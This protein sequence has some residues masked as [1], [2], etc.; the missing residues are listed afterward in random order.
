MLHPCTFRKVLSPPRRPLGLSG[1][2]WVRSVQ[3]QK[4]PRPVCSPPFPSSA[5]PLVS[6]ALPSWWLACV[7]LDM[8]R[9]R[10]CGSEEPSLQLAVQV[11]TTDYDP[12]RLWV[13]AV[14]RVITLPYM[15]GRAV[16][17]SRMGPRNSDGCLSLRVT[18][19]LLALNT[20]PDW[21]R[22]VLSIPRTAPPPVSLLWMYS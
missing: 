10:N 21:I 8:R 1:M 22:R 5:W 14:E 9:G 6:F 7:P 13:S 12:R 15:S 17:S 20:Y 4:F 19:A 2:D 3:S 16:M 11:P 18:A